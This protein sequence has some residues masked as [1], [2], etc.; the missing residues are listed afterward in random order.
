MKNSQT[1][2]LGTPE[3]NSDVV[4]KEP[5]V[6]L[7]GYGWVGQY[8]GKYFKKADYI[9]QDGIIHNVAN[10]DSYKKYTST[11][12]HVEPKEYDLAIISVPTPMNPKTGQCDVSIV[13]EVVN[14]YKNYVKYFLIKSTVEIGTTE[15]I[16]KQYGVKIA[17]SPEY[18][19]ETLGHPLLEPRRDAFQ[20]IGGDEETAS[21]VAEFF[22]LVLHASAPIMIC[23]STE[24]EI[25]KYCENMWI[26]Q[27]VDYWNDVYDIAKTLGGSFDRIREGLVL[28]PRFSRT[29]SFVYPEN[30]GWSGKCLPKDMNSLVYKMRKAGNPL[31]T[32]EFQIKKNAKKWRKDYANKEQLIPTEI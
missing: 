14:R 24:A 19:G 17:M 9:G 23:T 2:T 31:E 30:R 8:M 29:H 28:D 32:V 6:L 21:K 10:E 20:I 1:K 12:E 26:M 7:I 18:V 5:R 13:D 4:N 11:F 15:R 25:I 22:R 16:A 3:P 27:R